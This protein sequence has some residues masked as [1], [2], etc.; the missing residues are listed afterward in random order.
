M[1]ENV[2]TDVLPTFFPYVSPLYLFYLHTFMEQLVSKTKVTCLQKNLIYFAKNAERQ[3][4]VF[5][6][7]VLKSF[8]ISDFIQKD[9]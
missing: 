2:D 6:A 8:K 3:C 1:S 5:F 4:N 9:H 7:D